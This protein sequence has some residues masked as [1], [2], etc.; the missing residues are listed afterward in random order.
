MTYKPG[1]TNGL[2]LGA[3]AMLAVPV[4]FILFFAWIQT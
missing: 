1:T 3:F 4:L 2:I